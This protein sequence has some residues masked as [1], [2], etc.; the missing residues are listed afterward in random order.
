V[1]PGGAGVEVATATPL[2][3]VVAGVLG[4]VTIKS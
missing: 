3:I 4:V 2:L 1:E